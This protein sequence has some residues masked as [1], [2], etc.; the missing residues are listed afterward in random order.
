[1]DYDAVRLGLGA[2]FA[3]EV[4]DGIQRVLDYPNAWQLVERDLRRCRLHRFPYGLV[5]RASGREI[6]IVAVLHLS[7]DPGY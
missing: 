2:D 1:M 6:L 3:K 5:Y 7:R 4:D